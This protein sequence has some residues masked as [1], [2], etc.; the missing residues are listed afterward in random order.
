MHLY[1]TSFSQFFDREGSLKQKRTLLRQNK[2]P[3][4]DFAYPLLCSFK[5]GC[6]DLFS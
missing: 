3:T 2:K 4:E 6:M 5:Q 1:K